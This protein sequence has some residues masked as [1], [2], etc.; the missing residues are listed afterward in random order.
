MPAP[1][2]RS[3]LLLATLVLL[4]LLPATP[5]TGEL[6]IVNQVGFAFEPRDIT[7]QA[8][9]TIRWVR[10][11]GTHT[12]TSGS[13]CTFDGL[14]F[15]A[16]FD[17]ANPIFEFEV[18]ASFEGEL[19]YFCRPHCVVFDMVGT[20]TVVGDPCPADF[21]DSSAVDF[22]DLLAVLSEWGPCVACPQDI[23][24]DDEVG[25]SDLLILLAAWGPCP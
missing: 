21:D 4:L 24:G 15:D 11:D 22:Q 23:D 1:C 2:F 13:A 19:P 25:F 6:R 7:A 14:F 8:G 12:V 17:A 5:A 10:A 3:V 9:D 20:I 16:P 18:P